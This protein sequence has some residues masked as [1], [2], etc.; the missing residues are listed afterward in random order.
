TIAGD[1]GRRHLTLGPTAICKFCGAEA[2]ELSGG[3]T[4]ARRTGPAAAGGPVLL[5]EV[6]HRV[7]NDG[8]ETDGEVEWAAEQG[9]VF[10]L[11]SGRATADGSDIGIDGVVGYDAL[12]FVADQVGD[13]TK[14]EG[15]RARRPVPR[16]SRLVPPFV[17]DRDESSSASIST[18][19]GED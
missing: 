16:G 17:A 8:G 1:S 3:A 11:A 7:G 18:R 10:E 12:A 5:D 6:G 15:W 9:V 19:R 2:G 4:R 14:S 13:D